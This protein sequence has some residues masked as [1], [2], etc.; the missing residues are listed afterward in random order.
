MVGGVI[1]GYCATG[2]F[3][4]ATP[5]SNIVTSAMTFASTGR[6]MKN[7]A[8]MA[9][10]GRG[11]GGSPN[12]LTALTVLRSAHVWRTTKNAGTKSTARQVE[13]SIPL[14]T[15]IPS[16]RRALGPGPVGS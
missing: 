11:Q 9:G 16:E 5:P 8:S 14:A 13:A 10:D 2:R 4:M 12:E 7:L 15:A 6:S 3:T 1:G